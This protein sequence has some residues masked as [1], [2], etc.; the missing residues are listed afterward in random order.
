MALASSHVPRIDIVAFECS[1][2]EFTGRSVIRMGPKHHYRHSQ[3]CHQLFCSLSSMVAGSIKDDDC[4]LSPSRPL[5]IQFS[6]KLLEE[7]AKHLLI[8]VALGQ[9]EVHISEGVDSNQHRDP[10]HHL[11]GSNRV[12]RAGWLP[13]HPPPITHSQPRLITVEKH[14]IVMVQL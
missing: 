2:E 4:I 5:Q 7:E 14:H 3:L 6:Y 12:I 8:A 10:R 1:K 9:A 13:F 11:E